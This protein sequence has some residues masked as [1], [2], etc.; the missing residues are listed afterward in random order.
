MR[1]RARSIFAHPPGIDG[2]VTRGARRREDGE[3]GAS[4]VEFRSTSLALR[5]PLSSPSSRASRSHGN[6]DCWVGLL[7]TLCTGRV[8][9]VHSVVENH[10]LVLHG[11]EL[12]LLTNG[13]LQLREVSGAANHNAL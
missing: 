1:R 10:R 4:D 12:V 8:A 9:S 2:H 11:M 5:L 3:L 7:A 13:R 6:P